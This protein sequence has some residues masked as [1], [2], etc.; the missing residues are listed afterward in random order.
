MNNRTEQNKEE[1]GML[2]S[3]V[4]PV[5]SCISRDNNNSKYAIVPFKYLNYNQKTFISIDDQK[6]NYKG[7]TILKN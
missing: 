6:L 3:Q 5:N 4:H 1:T 2:G 7:K